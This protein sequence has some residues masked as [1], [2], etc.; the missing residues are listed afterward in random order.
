M[1][2]CF[3]WTALE[4]FLNIFE[5]TTVTWQYYCYIIRPHRSTTYVCTAYC[6][7][8]SSMVSRLV[9]L[10]VHLVILSH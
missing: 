5:Y 7:R 10:L 3:L 9:G 2:D 1:N 8:P 4:V 6:Y